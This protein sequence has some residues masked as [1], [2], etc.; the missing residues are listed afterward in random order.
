MEIINYICL[1]STHTMYMYLQHKC[2]T[3]SWFNIVSY[4]I[5]WKRKTLVQIL[6]TGKWCQSYLLVHQDIQDNIVESS[7]WLKD[8]LSSL[9]TTD[10]YPSVRI[11]V[12]SMLHFPNIQQWKKRL[13]KI[14]RFWLNFMATWH[15]YDIVQVCINYM[16]MFVDERS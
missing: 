12:W 6:S 13:F 15:L 5:F 3:C 9:N 16:Y 8:N 2:E 11:K 4:S 1:K 7:L 14:V 10:I